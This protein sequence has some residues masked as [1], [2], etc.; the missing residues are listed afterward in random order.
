MNDRRL[1]RKKK[2]YLLLGISFLK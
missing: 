1:M 2:N